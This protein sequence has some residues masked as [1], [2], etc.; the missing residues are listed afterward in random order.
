MYEYKDVCRLMR[1][2]FYRKT[3]SLIPDA[4]LS[5]KVKLNLF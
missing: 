2:A 3:E 1:T 4:D 5:M